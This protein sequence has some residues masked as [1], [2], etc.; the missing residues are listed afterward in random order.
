MEEVIVDFIY[1]Q[2]V[3]LVA[4]RRAGVPVIK[5]GSANYFFDS[6][7]HFDQS[8]LDS[9]A[10]GFLQAGSKLIKPSQIYNSLVFKW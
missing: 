10:S 9:I 8:E 5:T 4:K 1:P 6:S 3:G 7:L 2:P